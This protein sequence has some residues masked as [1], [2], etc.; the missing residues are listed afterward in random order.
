MRILLVEDNKGDQVILQEAFSEAGVSCDLSIVN[1]GVEAMEFM[2]KEGRFQ[3]AA[4]PDMVI[5]DLN[6][7]RKNGHEVL[8]EMRKTRNLEHIPVMVL[9]NSRAPNDVCTSYALR[10][11]VHVRKPSGFQGF[12]DLAKIIK[13]FW[14]DLACYCSH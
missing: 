6:L 9:S 11:N 10:A 8:A 13:T 1:D 5:L 3:D 12:V 4:K 14:I 7:P 2:K